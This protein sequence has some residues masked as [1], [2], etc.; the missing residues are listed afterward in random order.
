MPA[1]ERNSFEFAVKFIEKLEKFAKESVCTCVR[2]GVL[3]ACLSV[4]GLRWQVRKINHSN[5]RT[6]EETKLRKIVLSAAL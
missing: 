3:H 5:R 4:T 2:G 6:E 1:F